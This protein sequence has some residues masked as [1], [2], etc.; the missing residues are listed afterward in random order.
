MRN[1]LIFLT[2]I[3]I[4]SVE[5]NVLKV[6]ISNND[7]WNNYCHNDDD[8]DDDN[9]DVDNNDVWL[10]SGPKMRWTAC[11]WLAPTHHHLHIK[12]HQYQ[13]EGK[14][15]E[16]EIEIVMESETHQVTSHLHPGK[17]WKIASF[18]LHITWHQQQHPKN[19]PKNIDNKA[20]AIAIAAAAAAVTTINIWAARVLS[21]TWPRA[22]INPTF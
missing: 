20:I 10:S 3:T 5:K 2:T 6:W 7:H 22:L 15:R 16:K 11:R 14:R 4:L 12:I 8:D 1:H 21:E 19:R 17:W 13:V 18:S 9:Y